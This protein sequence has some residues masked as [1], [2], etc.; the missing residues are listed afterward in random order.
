[1][2]F[3]CG[4]RKSWLPQRKAKR[5]LG[6][7]NIKNHKQFSHI[8]AHLNLLFIRLSVEWSVRDDSD[9]DV[10]D[11]NAKRVIHTHIHKR[12]F[13]N[14]I[15]LNWIELGQLGSSQHSQCDSLFLCL[16]ILNLSILHVFL[17]ERRSAVF[18]HLSNAGRAY[19]HTHTRTR[20]MRRKWAKPSAKLKF[21]TW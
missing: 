3:S 19:R 9:Y 10:E 4:F 1:M 15:E 8:F 17:L 7:S 2:T 6:F 5:H 20:K 11:D 21:C 14:W 18:Y 13:T 16:S 12:T